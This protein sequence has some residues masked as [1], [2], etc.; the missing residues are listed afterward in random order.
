MI[1]ITDI[2]TAQSKIATAADF[3]QFIQDLKNMGIQQ[4][5]TIVENS[6]S[7]YWHTGG[8]PIVSDVKYEPLSLTYETDVDTFLVRLKLHQEGKTDYYTFCVDAANTGIEKWVMDLD[9]MT[10]TYFDHTCRAVLVEN[11]PSV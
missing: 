1:T 2:E 10:C 9:Q 6:Q 7:I 4:F 8:K 5:S 3:P 11:V